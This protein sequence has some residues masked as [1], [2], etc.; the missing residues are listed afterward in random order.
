MKLGVHLFLLIG[1][2]PVPVDCRAWSLNFDCSCANSLLGE[3]HPPRSI[4]LRRL[5]PMI[6]YIV[7]FTLLIF[8]PA[9]YSCLLE[10]PLSSL[11]TSF[12]LISGFSS[13]ELILF[14]LSFFPKEVITPPISF[15]FRLLTPRE[16]KVDFW[17][18]YLCAGLHSQRCGTRGKTSC[19]SFFSSS[20]HWGRWN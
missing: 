8:R 1:G 5:P 6:W 11:I 19:R 12:C 17:S 20:Y 18:F 14:L 10:S 9:S 7:F 4:C 13:I 2:V 3:R 15:F 16:G